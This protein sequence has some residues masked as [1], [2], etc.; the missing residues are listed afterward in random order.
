MA[1]K[2]RQKPEWGAEREGPRFREERR[3]QLET[4]STRRRIKERLLL[5]KDDWDEEETYVR[6][7][8]KRSKQPD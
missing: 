4:T 2:R 5:R 8:G 3:A 1:E 6:E 7:N